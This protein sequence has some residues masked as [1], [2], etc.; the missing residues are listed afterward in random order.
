MTPFLDYLKDGVLPTD[1][2]EAK[3]LMFRAANYTLIDDILY[4]QGFSFPYLR[5]L[6]VEEGIRVL[7]ELHA[8]ECSNHIQAQSLYIKVLCLGYYWPTMR[9]NSKYIR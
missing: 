7:E 1:K 4:K 8:G 9:T 5:C 3:S 2:K 6:R